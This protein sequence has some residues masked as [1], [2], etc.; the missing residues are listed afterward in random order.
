MALDHASPV[1]PL[2]GGKSPINGSSKGSSPNKHGD[3]MASWRPTNTLMND[4]PK[5]QAQAD[6]DRGAED[7]AF[8]AKIKA[9]LAEPQITEADI[10]YGF[11]IW[12][13][14]GPKCLTSGK[15]WW[16]VVVHDSKV[17][18]LW[19]F[20]GLLLMVFEVLTIPYRLVLFVE[21][22]GKWFTLELFTLTYFWTDIFSNFFLSYGLG[23]GREVKPARIIAKYLKGWFILDVLASFPFKMLITSLSF[24]RML[25]LV[26]F[27]RYLRILRLM[28][29]LKLKQKL[30]MLEQSAGD[31][32]VFIVFIKIGNVFL[33]LVFLSHYS[34]CLWYMIGSQGLP[35]GLPEICYEEPWNCPEEGVSWLSTGMVL[36]EG[37]EGD[38]LKFQLYVNSLYWA[39]E[40]MTCVGYGDFGM[41]NSKEKIFAVV[42]FVVSVTVFSGVIN[43]LQQ[44]FLQLFITEMARRETMR[45]MVV[46]TKW[47]GIGG[48]LK[49]RLRAFMTFIYDEDPITKKQRMQAPAVDSVFEKTTPA[50]SREICGYVYGQHLRPAPYMKWLLNYEIAFSSLCEK[51]VCSVYAPGDVVCVVQEKAAGFLTLME[52]VLMLY[53]ASVSHGLPG[54]DDARSH[55][56][57]E[58]MVQNARRSVF[59]LSRQV[60]R[61]KVE[62]NLV[63]QTKK[64]QE[65]ALMESIVSRLRAKIPLPYGS[66]LVNAPAFL[67]QECFLG[68]T[69]D[70]NKHWKWPYSVWCASYSEICTV[71][72]TGLLAVLD[73][74][75]FLRPLYEAFSME[76]LQEVAKGE[77]PSQED[78]FAKVYAQLEAE[79]HMDRATTPKENLGGSSSP[80]CGTWEYLCG[81]R[82]YNITEKKGIL[83][84]QQSDPQGHKFVT[85]SLHR[86]EKHEEVHEA[87]L[88]NRGRICLRYYT[89][90]DKATGQKEDHMESRYMPPGSR[91]WGHPVPAVRVNREVK[92]L[93]DMHRQNHLHK[94]MRALQKKM[95]AVLEQMGS[96][97]KADGRW[98]V[99][100]SKKG[101]RPEDDEE[102][103]SFI[104]EEAEPATRGSTLSTL[105]EKAGLR[106][107]SKSKTQNEDAPRLPGQPDAF[108]K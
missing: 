40:T 5:A 93:K 20:I 8:K 104:V 4:S 82:E 51:C 78:F 73:D 92:E 18:L 86:K 70:F 88:S 7:L 45:K 106:K 74:F 52:G 68:V 25:R 57:N 44:V 22:T 23:D 13:Q 24:A 72:L 98:K 69:S 50:L 27:A 91:K 17:R 99:H 19:E 103:A 66:C 14:F 47:R 77:N 107:T 63:K 26:R 105:T 28:K 46:W 58:Y 49:I 10:E 75:P 100:W 96:M 60:E 33:I 71:P 9:A 48:V 42:F 6:S 76:K 83:V 11:L 53:Q 34:A 54:K 21:P 61:E 102:R 16:P 36:D 55:H 37:V 97:V 65:F 31:F 39:L 64:S 2:N 15:Q 38:E 90:I 67:G 3:E 56:N 80:L 81:Q 62:G 30:L 12:M 94:E 85:G 87:I 89:A 32:R 84:F 95:S 35:E 101:G 108:S 79:K 29:A 41:T 1:V 43:S 59:D